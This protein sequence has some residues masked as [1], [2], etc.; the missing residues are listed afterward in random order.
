MAATAEKIFEEMMDA[1]EGAFGEGW[2]AVKIYAPAE[3]RKMAVQL[4]EIAENVAWDKLDWEP[5]LE[6]LAQASSAVCFGTLAQR[7]EPSRQGWGPPLTCRAVPESVTSSRGS[8]PSPARRATS[9]SSASTRCFASSTTSAC[10]RSSHASA[11]C[12]SSLMFPSI[13]SML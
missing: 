2:D 1:A 5:G 11:R 6:Q 9:S 10:A 3:F 4:E 8:M 13:T 7:S 12:R